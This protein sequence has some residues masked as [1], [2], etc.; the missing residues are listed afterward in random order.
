[1]QSGPTSAQT[2]LSDALGNPASDVAPKLEDAIESPAELLKP[3]REV[4]FAAQ[5]ACLLRKHVHI[6]ALCQSRRLQMCYSEQVVECLK[7][8]AAA[9]HC[10][11]VQ[12]STVQFCVLTCVSFD[13]Q[14]F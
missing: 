1:M 9:A 12:Q 3:G 14:Q 8:T 4:G 6:W 11:D 13:Q 5:H 7:A 2:A 10:C